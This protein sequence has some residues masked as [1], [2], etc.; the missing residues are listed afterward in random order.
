MPVIPTH[1]VSTP[2]PAAMRWVVPDG[3]LPFAGEVAHAPGL[4]QGLLDD[5]TLASIQVVPGAVLTLL[6]E[7]RAWRVEGARVRT[8][9]VDAL[10]LPQRW[11]PAVTAHAV[12]PDEALEAAAREI[13]G[14]PVG[15]IARS[16]GGSFTVLSVHDGVVEV[17]L[18][19]ACHDCPAAVITMHARFE[20]LLRR[21]CPWLTEV[22]KAPVSNHA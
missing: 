7:G 5:G 10:G 1:P 15:V 21:R 22:R 13:A 16:H 17:G 18:E 19:G 3:L 6:G 4:L 9:L 8:A 2:D 14:G 11:Q 12:G 20:H